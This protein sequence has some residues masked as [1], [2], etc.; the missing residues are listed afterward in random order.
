MKLDMDKLL[1]RKSKLIK[2][3]DKEDELYDKVYENMHQAIWTGWNEDPTKNYGLVATMLY[4]N[5]RVVKDILPYFVG[6]NK[7]AETLVTMQKEINDLVAKERHVNGAIGVYYSTQPV[8][9]H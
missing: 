2:E 5:G 6:T 1:P 4:T 9:K 8:Y 3:V 7:L